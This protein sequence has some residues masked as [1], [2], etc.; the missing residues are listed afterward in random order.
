MVPQ[1]GV[2]GPQSGQPAP[3]CCAGYPG[4]LV[5]RLVSGDSEEK[6]LATMLDALMITLRITDE[7]TI[8]R[9]DPQHGV[10]RH[11]LS[12]GL[13]PWFQRF[14]EF[15][16]DAGMAAEALRQKRPMVCQHIEGLHQCLGSPSQPDLEVLNN[17][18]DKSTA[19]AYAIALPVCWGEGA[20]G[21]LILAPHDS[22]HPLDQSEIQLAKAFSG[23]MAI[24]MRQSYLGRQV[25]QL[26]QET[27]LQHQLW[28]EKS[29]QLDSLHEI[30]SLSHSEG[31][32]E[33]VVKSII[34]WT[35]E[36]IYGLEPATV[37]AGLSDEPKGSMTL[38]VAAPD[39]EEGLRQ[40]SV[41]GHAEHLKNLFDQWTDSNSRTFSAGDTLGQLAQGLTDAS[42]ESLVIGFPLHTAGKTFGLLGILLSPK[43]EL[44]RE[45]KDIIQQFADV[46]ALCLQNSQLFEAQ[47]R[48]TR[49]LRH[50]DELRRSFLSYI[51]YE[52]RT[53]LA[54]LKTSFELIQES[55]KIRNLDEP[56]QRLLTNVNRSVTTLEQLIN[57]LAEVANLS[58][59]GVVLNK[60]LIPPEV[61]IYPVVE[62]TA[63]LSHLKNQSLEVEVRPQLPQLMADARRLEQVLTNIV[64][65]AVKYTPAGGAIRTTVSQENGSIKF[66]VSDNG[67]GIPQEDLERVF[68]PFYRAPLQAADRTPGTGLGLALAKSLVELHGGKIWVESEPQKGSTFYFTIPIEPR[69]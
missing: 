42:D 30:V 62:M 68:E 38:T 10:L 63:P 50:E 11:Q 39:A 41:G 20:M 22:S 19:P 14:K 67:K 51:T 33:K 5:R 36:Q 54:S 4:R 44:D 61:I 52:L 28:M 43:H 56:Y 23:Y 48:Q 9:H 69:D 13:R 27:V 3:Y 40:Q 6:L 59:G 12:L 8:Y 55:E 49:E 66:A 24:A 47:A 32:Q 46:A 64:S 17:S 2:R 31:N 21:V 60:T 29:R 58:S 37:F 57:D 34:Q 25:A 16:T 1:Y 35:L 65:N 53:P 18:S 15:P 26:D 7:G 45:E